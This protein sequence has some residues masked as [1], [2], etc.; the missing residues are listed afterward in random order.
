MQVL[1]VV[2][3]HA[4][5]VALLLGPARHAGL[6]GHVQSAQWVR[7]GSLEIWAVQLPQLALT[8]V[9]LFVVAL[10]QIRMRPVGGDFDLLVQ[11][12]KLSLQ[13]NVGKGR[14]HL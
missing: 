14:G 2:S 6:V 11:L 3:A 4:S 10:E 12:A 7:Q 9:V 8:E 5:A 1:A 13:G